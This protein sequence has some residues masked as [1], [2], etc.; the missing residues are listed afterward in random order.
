MWGCSSQNAPPA[1]GT[2]AF[3][4]SAAQETFAAGDY[5]KTVDHLGK[6]AES[7]SEYKGRAMPW[8]LVM[9][10]GMTRGYTDLAES[11]EA[12]ARVRKADPAPFRR[13][14]SNYR[15]MA[16]RYSL[17]FAEAFAEFQKAPKDTVELAFRYPSGSPGQPPQITKVSM[18]GYLQGPES[19]TAEKRSVE[20]GIL[21]EACR[22]VG[23][24]NDAAKTQE[25]FKPGSVQV[26]K[27]TFLNG[28][29]EVLHEQAQ[30]YGRRKLDQ[31]DKLKIFCDRALEVVKQLPDSKDRKELEKKI[32]A[33][34][35]ENKV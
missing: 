30:L 18:G 16:A 3:Y 11:Y 6:L 15:T 13:N 10:A 27:A 31:P 35:K 22:A 14:M 19:Q 1:K 7:D 34:L 5:V 33:T 9:T 12:G 17:Q 8:L 25:I 29:A 26:A 4:W 21:L 24:P 20:R 2:P 32:G 23:A 28:M